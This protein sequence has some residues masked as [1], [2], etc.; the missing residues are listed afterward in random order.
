METIS[1]RLENSIYEELSAILDSIGS[2]KA[3][4]L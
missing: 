2:D 1:I 4:I 3:D